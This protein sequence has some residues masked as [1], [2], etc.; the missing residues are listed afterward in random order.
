MFRIYVNDNG[1]INLCQQ[2]DMRIL[3]TLTL[4]NRIPEFSE[5]SLL[6]AML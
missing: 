3:S 6:L 4:S 5:I 2:E 1:G